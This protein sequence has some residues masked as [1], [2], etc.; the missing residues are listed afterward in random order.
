MHY[1]EHRMFNY[2]ESDS[3]CAW[4]IFYIMGAMLRMKSSA[5]GGTTEN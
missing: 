5:F 3:D 1:K 4:A 2:A